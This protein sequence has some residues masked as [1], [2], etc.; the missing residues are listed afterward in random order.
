LKTVI[1]KFENHIVFCMLFSIA[2]PNTF[3]PTAEVAQNIACDRGLIGCCCCN[4]QT[5]VTNGI[6]QSRCP[7]WNEEE[8]VAMTATDMKLAGLV[9]FL[10]FAYL[11]GALI[12]AGLLRQNLKNYKS[13]FV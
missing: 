8:V 10:S 7:Q 2:L 3:I 13:E 9:A 1:L 5:L 12:V 4:N 6:Y 11:L